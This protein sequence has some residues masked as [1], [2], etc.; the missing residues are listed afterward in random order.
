MSRTK[1]PLNNLFGRFVSSARK[2]IGYNQQ[3]LAAVLGVTS[4]Y[5][6]KIET[7]ER[8]VPNAYILIQ[9]ADFLNVKL[10]KLM[11]AGGIMVDVMNPD[12]LDRVMQELNRAKTFQ[13]L[14]EASNVVYEIACVFEKHHYRLPEDVKDLVNPLKLQGKTLK[15]AFVD[16]PRG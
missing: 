2:K 6:S 9:L 1:T 10:S 15:E 16:K 14:K 4:N 11:I 7:G 5:L 3:E 13:Q 8:G 12:K